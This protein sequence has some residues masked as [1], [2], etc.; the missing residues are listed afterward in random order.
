MH[1]PDGILPPLIYG[2]GYAITVGATAIALRKINQ[3]EDPRAEIPKAA[4]LTAAFFVVSSL[5]IPMPPPLNS[6][7]L[8]LTGLMG[9]MLGWY[10][11]PSILV[12]LILQFIVV[13]AWRHHHAWRQRLHH[14]VAS[15][16]LAL[17]F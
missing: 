16:C 2:G 14:G 8:V 12:G 11:F 9:V 5:L 4:L 17:Y 10:A 1:V 6:V 15:D 13:S 3:Q 7:H